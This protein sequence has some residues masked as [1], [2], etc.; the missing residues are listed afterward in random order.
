MQRLTRSLV[1]SMVLFTLAIYSA[2]AVAPNV[3][4]VPDGTPS[5]TI[6]VVDGNAS[7]WQTSPLDASNKDWYGPICVPSASVPCPNPGADIFMRVSCNVATLA[8]DTLYLLVVMRSPHT[9]GQH[10]AVNTWID[11]GGVSGHVI[12]DGPPYSTNSSPNMIRDLT[13]GTGY[14]AAISKVGANNTGPGLANGQTYNLIFNL[15]IDGTSRGTDPRAVTM[16]DCH[17][18]A[19]TVTSMSAESSDGNFARAMGVLGAFGVVVLG[20]LLVLVV[21]NR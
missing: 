2:F 6:P 18:T 9:F 7:E 19:V 16:P 12:V 11:I 3:R 1:L 4:K 8:P 14:E 13:N 20:G 21:R 10:N 5:G 17:P 15:S